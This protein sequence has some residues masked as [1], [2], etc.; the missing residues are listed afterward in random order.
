[1]EILIK[2]KC[3]QTEKVIS[4]WIGRHPIRGRVKERYFERGKH[5]QVASLRSVIV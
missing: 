1:M 3:H 2:S 4:K 5:K